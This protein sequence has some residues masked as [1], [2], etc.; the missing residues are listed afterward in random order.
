VSAAVR[1]PTLAC[2]PVEDEHPFP[3]AVRREIEQGRLRA[4]GRARGRV[5]DLGAPAG[6]ACLAAVINGA[7][8]TER[9]DTVVSGGDLTRFPDLVGALRAVVAV[10]APGGQVEVVEPVNHVCRGHTLLATLWSRHPAVAAR[11]V[12]RDVP[13]AMRAVGLTLGD[14]ERVDV[15]TVV[16]SLRQLV[17]VRARIVPSMANLGHQRAGA[18]A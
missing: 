6:R 12:E 4:M 5:L 15:P 9:Y 13:A 2:R 18:V 7:D 1:P 8:P 3:D 16:W 11:H 17:H 10:L 14:L